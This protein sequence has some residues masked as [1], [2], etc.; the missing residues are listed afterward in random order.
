MV[1]KYQIAQEFLDHLK[2][3]D[4]F[5]NQLPRS[6]EEAFYENEAYTTKD[7]MLHILLKQLLK[8]SDYDDLCYF[9][10]ESNPVYFVDDLEFNTLESYWNYLDERVC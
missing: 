9:A 7:Q 10:Y 6:V 4:A 2:E 5:F 1:T 8:E 3:C